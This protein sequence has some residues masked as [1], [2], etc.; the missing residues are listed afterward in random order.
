MTRQYTFL[1]ND[2]KDQ[3]EA[4]RTEMNVSEKYALYFGKHMAVLAEFQSRW[5]GYLGCIYSDQHRIEPQD[6]DI[7]LVY[8]A[9]HQARRTTM[10]FE[11]AKI[12]ITVPQEITKHV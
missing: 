10:K 8:L 5:G 9:P 2:F 11:E 3:S 12:K 4:L 1:R 7:I 6:K